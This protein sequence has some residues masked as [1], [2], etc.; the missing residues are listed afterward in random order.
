[1][2]DDPRL[3]KIELRAFLLVPMCPGCEEIC[4]RKPG[5]VLTD[6]DKPQ[7]ETW[8]CPSC[9]AE[10]EYPKGQLPHLIHEEVQ[11]GQFQIPEL[12]KVEA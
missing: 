12:N 3:A 4:A 1:M 10:T 2:T 6:A 5:L 7:M 9:G 8:A 11:T